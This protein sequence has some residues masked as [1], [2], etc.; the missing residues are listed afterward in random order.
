MLYELVYIPTLFWLILASYNEASL[1]VCFS[2]T[3]AAL[4]IL[5]WVVA[6]LLCHTRH[7]SILLLGASV[8]EM[9]LVIPR[10]NL[11]RSRI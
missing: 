3:C 11:V 7:V 6:R 2:T 1:E 8:G 5:L 10:Y 9:M 4:S